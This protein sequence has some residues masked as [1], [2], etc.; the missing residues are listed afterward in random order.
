[1]AGS[2]SSTLSPLAPPFTAGRAVSRAAPPY[3]QYYAV[4]SQGQDC[5]S[6]LSEFHQNSSKAP[7][8]LRSPAD[9]DASVVR[10]GQEPVSDR[11]FVHGQCPLSE[12]YYPP[13]FSLDAA[14]GSG[15]QSR[16][17]DYRNGSL[18]K[19]ASMPRRVVVSCPSDMRRG[20]ND[21]MESS[22]WVEGYGDLL[23]GWQE[24]D[25]NSV[26][27]ED[28]FDDFDH[29]KAN[30]NSGFSPIS[31]GISRVSPS[32]P[33][34]G[35]DP[36]LSSQMA[37]PELSQTFG[38]GKFSG[39]YVGGFDTLKYN[40]LTFQNG[41]P[42]SVDMFSSN[43][44]NLGRSASECGRQISFDESSIRQGDLLRNLQFQSNE[45]YP[46]S[47]IADPMHGTGNTTI[48][49]SISSRNANFRI[50]DSVNRTSVDPSEHI[51]DAMATYSEKLG[52]VEPGNPENVNSSTFEEHLA[53]DSPCWKGVSCYECISAANDG[54][55]GKTFDSFLRRNTDS[56]AAD[57][58]YVSH[59]ALAIDRSLNEEH[60]NASNL[61]PLTG[62]A[63]QSSDAFSF[64]NLDE[65]MLAGTS[66]TNT[67]ED[68]FR[69]SN[70]STTRGS[71]L[72]LDAQLLVKTVHNL[73]CVLL[74]SCRADANALKVCD[75]KILQLAVDNLG[76][77]IQSTHELDQARPDAA[78]PSGCSSHEEIFTPSR[79]KEIPGG[80]T[81]DE[82]EGNQSM[83]YEVE[84]AVHHLKHKLTVLRLDLQPRK[85]EKGD[86]VKSQSAL[87]KPVEPP[88]T[89]PLTR[90]MPLDVDAA[91]MDRFRLLKDR[92]QR[93][94]FLDQEQPR[95]S[96]QSGAYVD[97]CH[98]AGPMPRGGG[99]GWR[100]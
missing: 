44:R 80:R 91:V 16:D 12:P 50:T 9:Y 2:S 6:N 27:K 24:K 95:G 96:V 59:L 26:P 13:F 1:M 81:S 20:A 88:L 29:F 70:P 72:L 71:E 14:S 86:L 37:F 40:P 18:G 42:Y 34:E 8:Q 61:E 54:S 64:H 76:I 30:K 93:C 78:C 38:S 92:M 43:G 89:P 87:V 77:C 52:A 39:E 74:E 100:S 4:W 58:K 94:N 65:Y 62:T 36:Y 33:I 31:Q 73:S 25:R 79:F 55:S 22:P 17:R 15:G 32:A 57:S 68:T 35:C 99:S 21:K 56:T 45:G 28:V 3:D 53:V 23:R 60:A 19:S 66:Q 11:G 69:Q 84:E 75:K 98:V 41:V 83:W 5:S 82:G 10:H 51:S 46:T 63:K 7:S 85:G 48:T 49:D 47:K 90:P 67:L 97:P